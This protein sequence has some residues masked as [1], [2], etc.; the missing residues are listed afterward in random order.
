MPGIGGH[1][2]CRIGRFQFARSRRYGRPDQ[3][4][5]RRST[6]LGGKSAVDGDSHL[7]F[8]NCLRQGIIPTSGIYIVIL[9]NAPVQ[10]GVAV[11]GSLRTAAIKLAVK[12]LPDVPAQDLSK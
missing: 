5:R 6:T 10:W 8:H 9:L 3:R 12:R 11:A 2:C 1:Q 7:K 4:K